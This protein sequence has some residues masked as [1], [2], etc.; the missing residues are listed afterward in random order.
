MLFFSTQ[1]NINYMDS[2]RFSCSAQSCLMVCDPMDCSTPGFPVHHQ[3]PELLEKAQTQKEDDHMKMV[4]ETGV[5]HLHIQDG[6]GLPALT[7]I[8]ET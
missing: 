4:E 8:R 3:L 1:I 7:H 2:V 6:Q 5:M